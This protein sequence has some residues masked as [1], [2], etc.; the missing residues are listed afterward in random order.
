MNQYVNR[1]FVICLR[2]NDMSNKKGNYYRDKGEY[3]KNGN[4]RVNQ[5]CN[6]SQ[7]KQWPH[8]VNL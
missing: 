2:Q 8:H 5:S 4:Y 3:L 7:S 6:H 1:F